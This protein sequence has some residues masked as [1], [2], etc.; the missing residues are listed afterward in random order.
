MCIEIF[1]QRRIHLS[2]PGYRLDAVSRVPQ[3]PF[4]AKEDVMTIRSPRFFPYL[5]LLLALGSGASLAA[6]GAA[7]AEG[8]QPQ[9]MFCPADS[10]FVHRGATRPFSRRIAQL[11]CTCCGKDENG[12]CN[13]QCCN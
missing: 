10:S 7:M 1:K 5:A 13:H 6:S 12:H 9:S 4:V 2:P 3:S 8:T 11:H